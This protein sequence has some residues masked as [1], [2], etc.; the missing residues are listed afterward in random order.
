MYYRL[1]VIPVALP[2]LRDRGADILLLAESFLARYSSEEG[3]SSDG[4]ARDAEE[5]LVSNTWPGNVRELENLLQRAGV[6]ATSN[7]LLPQDL[8]L[9]H[10]NDTMKSGFNALRH[11]AET[12]LNTAKDSDGMTPVEV[13]TRELIIAARKTCEDDKSVAKL[14]G[15]PVAKVT[16]FDS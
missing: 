3:K 9:D 12:I 15:I 10:G 13:A 2:P 5:W 7:V 8:P 6:L 11:A 1:H 16:A 14:L 4:F